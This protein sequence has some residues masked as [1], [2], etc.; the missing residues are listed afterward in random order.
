MCQ[1]ELD[2]SGKSI[3]FVTREYEFDNKFNPYRSFKSLMIPGKNTNYNNIKKETYTLHV[4]DNQKQVN[5]FVYEYN[6]KGY[7]VRVNK[8][9]EYLYK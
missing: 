9:T 6:G 8:T 2:K 4:M 3:L 1:Y 5:E 7:P